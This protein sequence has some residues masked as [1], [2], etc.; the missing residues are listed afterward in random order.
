M[1]AYITQLIYNVK[2]NKT[3]DTTP[4]PFQLTVKP[5]PP[6]DEPEEPILLPIT[7]PIYAAPKVEYINEVDEQIGTKTKS[8]EEKARAE[9][10]KLQNEIEKLNSELKNSRYK[11][12]GSKKSKALE[13]FSFGWLKELT[14][15]EC[16]LEQNKNSS[17][18]YYYTFSTIRF[19]NDVVYLGNSDR[20][21]S[22]NIEE[23]ENLRLEVYGIEKRVTI[24]LES[25]SVK[26]YHVRAKL[27]KSEDKS[28]IDFATIQKARIKVENRSFIWSSV[29]ALLETLNYQ[30]DINLEECATREGIKYIYGPP[31]TGKT[32]NI[33]EHQLSG[34]KS[35]M[36]S[37]ILI[38]AP[39][40]K[41]ADVITERL[42]DSKPSFNYFR[43]GNTNSE[44]IEKH[45]CFV[46]TD[47]EQRE[48]SFTLIT[49][50][51]RYFYAQLWEDQMIMNYEW[52]KIIIDEASMINLAQIFGV[53]LKTH[54]KTKI[55][56]AGDPHQIQPIVSAENCKNISIFDVIGLTDFSAENRQKWK[57][58]VTFLTNQYR[59]ARS[60][61]D[62][63]GKFC[64]S[65]FVDTKAEIGKSYYMLCNNIK[66][67]RLNFVTYPV[68]QNSH[69]CQPKYLNNSSYHLYLAL[70]INEWISVFTQQF[71]NKPKTIGI[72]SPYR[73]QSDLLQKLI[74]SGSTSHHGSQIIV[75]TVHSFQGDECDIIVCAFN[76]PNKGHENNAIN[77]KNII[78]VAISRAKEYLILFMPDNFEKYPNLK[79][80][81]TI[82]DKSISPKTDITAA[83][84]EMALFG[85][86]DKIEQ[87]T[88]STA[89]HP[90]NVFGNSQYR[91]E[92]K[93]EDDALDI[94]VNVN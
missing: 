56:I 9:Q 14:K 53:I 76:P 22:N 52:D 74:H 10:K 15:L 45:K 90:I 32:R 80:L 37:K 2:T 27:A 4:S 89:H 60:I 77:N 63:Y 28:V 43:F 65:G 78:N 3:E 64:Y 55:I 18:S 5:T 87:I 19:E 70:L 46:G 54:E 58:Q 79:E 42:I 92:I 13:R 93:V 41:A 8:D 26:G 57:N 38:L 31:G 11:E 84:L 12:L 67:N 1:Q 23:L 81:K 48:K 35:T 44:K 21:V 30:N 20:L 94:Q 73:A 36:K 33:I 17:H 51:A 82:F 68:L 16:L 24:T 85:E 62:L 88:Y 34:D 83:E 7:K 29:Q 69:L 50:T 6:D 86:V 40:N 75:S 39:T 72:I 49:T 71:E 61:G 25:V 91:Y 59:S 66:M 47:F